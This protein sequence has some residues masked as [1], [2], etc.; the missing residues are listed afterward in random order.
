MSRALRDRTTKRAGASPSGRGTSALGSAVNFASQGSAGWRGR[1]RRSAGVLARAAARAHTLGPHAP[2]SLGPCWHSGPQQLSGEC[3]REG[4]WRGRRGVR[5]RRARNFL[6]GFPGGQPTGRSPRPP[7]RLRAPAPCRAGRWRGAEFAASASRALAGGSAFVR[8][9][10][11]AP[12]P[13]SRAA[14]RPTRGPARHRP[15]SCCGRALR[16]WREA[17]RNERETK[18]QWAFLLFVRI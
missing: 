8:S 18:G 3:G 13:T 4:S 10:P 2:R 11:G 14:R 15:R 16:R 7:A 17:E 1:R 6:G 9:R 5:G 12:S